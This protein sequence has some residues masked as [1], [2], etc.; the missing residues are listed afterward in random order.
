[1]QCIRVVE[2]RENK[3]HDDNASQASNLHVN[4]WF[5]HR[6]FS[7]S[8]FAIANNAFPLH[9]AFTHATTALYPVFVGSPQFIGGCCANR[10][11]NC[12][13]HYDFTQFVDAPFMSSI[14]LTLLT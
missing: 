5:C 12:N 14:R 10:F 4:G 2:L 11:I 6:S 7:H 9:T 1:M 3:I 8:V 13:F